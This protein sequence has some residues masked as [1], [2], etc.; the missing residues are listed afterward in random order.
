MLI[1]TLKT[2]V[3]AIS[4]YAWKINIKHGL[5]RS[6]SVSSYAAETLLIS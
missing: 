4:K 6:A 1:A 3:V 5:H 2:K